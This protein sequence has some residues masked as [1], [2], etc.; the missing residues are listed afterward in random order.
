VHFTG[1]GCTISQAS[2]SV[3]MEALDEE[4]GH[5]TL[6]HVL[7]EMHA[8]EMEELL[9]KETMQVRPR[10][11]TLSLDTL[12]AAIRKYQREKLMRDNGLDPKNYA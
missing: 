3:L 5:K 11:A 2:A 6:A 12:K 9:G 1:E 8:E 10:C 7:D 4:G